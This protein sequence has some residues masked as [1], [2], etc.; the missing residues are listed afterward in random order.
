[1]IRNY[2]GEALQKYYTEMS[3]EEIQSLDLQLKM[4]AY[5]TL[6]LFDEKQK[7]RGP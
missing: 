1:L 7:I 5:Q 3:V 4:L 6:D 2:L